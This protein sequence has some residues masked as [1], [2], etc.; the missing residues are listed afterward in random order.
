MWVRRIRL[1]LKNQNKSFWRQKFLQCLTEF[2]CNVKFQ[3][4]AFS[5]SVPSD[6]LNGLLLSF[7]AERR[8]LVQKKFFNIIF[9]IINICQD[10]LRR[11]LCS[12]CGFKVRIPVME[13][14]FKNTGY[15]KLSSNFLSK[16]RLQVVDHGKTVPCFLNGKIVVRGKVR[17]QLLVYHGKVVVVN[18]KLLVYHGKV[19]KVLVHDMLQVIHGK[20]EEVHGKLLVHH[21]KV[22]VVNGKLAVVQGSWQQCMASYWCIMVRQQQQ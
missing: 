12:T 5:H 3:Q 15:D 2:G 16:A 11:I 22:V 6:F 21:C 19:N 9:Y 4:R 13:K 1:Q 8:A 10:G 7:F 17:F 20:V 14:Y 18:E